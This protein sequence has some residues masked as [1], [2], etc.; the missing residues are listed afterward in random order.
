M[1]FGTAV[2]DIGPSGNVQ[3]LDLAVDVAV[4]G[5]F[6]GPRSSCLSV[7]RICLGCC[8]GSQGVE[9]R[10]PLAPGNLGHGVGQGTIANILNEHG[11]EPAPERRK[12]TTWK[13][14]LRRHGGGDGGR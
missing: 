5:G 3:E 10:S 9:T 7:Q 1:P 6:S 4:V 14:F 8:A 12:K 13:E 11:I 2:S